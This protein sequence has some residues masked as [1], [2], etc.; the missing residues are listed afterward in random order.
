LDELTL[1]TSENFED[2][3]CDFYTDGDDF[4]ITREQIGTALGYSDPRAS[5][6]NIHVRHKER[7]DNLSRRYQITMKHPRLKAQKESPYPNRR[8]NID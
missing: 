2:I 7:L 5:I 4:Y 1:V 6:G 8:E 3:E